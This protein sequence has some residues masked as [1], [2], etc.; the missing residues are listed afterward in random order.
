MLLRMMIPVSAFVPLVPFLAGLS[1]FTTHNATKR[2][3]WLLVTVIFVAEQVAIWLWF[4]KTSNVW[5]FHF[6]APL[7]ALGWALVYQQ[8]FKGRVWPKVV[9]AW[10]L[11]MVP[12]AVINA[13][14]WQQPQNNEFNSHVIMVLAIGMVV[15]AVS[16]F[17]HQLTQP[18][19][20]PLKSYFMLWVTSAN[21]LYFTGGLFYFISVQYIQV[22]GTAANWLFIVNALFNIMRMVIYAKA[23]WMRPAAVKQ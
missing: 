8:Q 20:Q 10:G 15:I 18:W 14:W 22:K 12:F 9:M 1:R 11:L 5:V 17:M 21:L 6:L 13:I 7:E 4:Q 2:R 19:L 16:F 23:L 3:L